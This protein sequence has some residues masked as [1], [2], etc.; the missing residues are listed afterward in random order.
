MSA[1]I[2][3][4]RR[5]TAL[6]GG[7]AAFIEDLYERYLQ[8][9][10]SIPSA[11][12]G[13][14]DAMHQEAA[15][16][17]PHGPVRENFR[18]LARER[19]SRPTSRAGGA[20]EPVAAEK[21]AAVLR[22]INAYRYRGH[23]VADLDPLVL[24]EKPQV[25]DLDP[26]YHNLQPEDF[27]QV[28][29]TGSLYAP[30]RMALREIVALV[31]QI[32]CGPVGSEYM[33]IIS[34][35]QKRWIQKR[36]EGYRAVPELDGADRRWLLTLLTAAEGLE[37]YLHNRYVGQKRFSL[38]GG[39]AL[40]PLIDELIQRAG[41]QGLKEIVIGMAHRGRL[42]V[43]TNILGK[44]PQ[45]MFDEFEGRVHVSWRE[46]AGDVKYHMGFA[47]DIDTP[48]GVVHVVL[49]FNPS[50]LEIIDP[51]IEGS[52]R[53]RQR[54]RLDRTGD[55]VLPVLIHGDAAFAGQGVVAETLQLSQ[56]RGYSTGG[57]VHIVVNNQ[58]GFT[59]S[60]PL[61]TRS[62]LYCTDVAKMVQAPV[63]HVNGDDPEAVIFATRLALDF[64]NQFHKD[65]II[66]LVCYRRL[67]HNEADEPSVTQPMM[68]KKIRGHPTVR[69]RYAERLTEAGEL[70]KDAGELMVEDYR[71]S[72]EQGVVVARPVLCGLDNPYKVDWGDCRGDDWDSAEV[73]TGVARETLC[74]LTEQMLRVP[75]GFELHPRV[76][77][78]WGER[79]NMAHGDQLINWGYAEN[80]AYATLLDAGFPVRLSGQDAG[81]GT[82]FHR[83]AVIHDQASGR[84]HTP[85]QH[86]GPHQGAFVAI[87]SILSEEA[88]LAF[89]YGYATAEP[90]A[91]TLWEAQFGDFANGAQVVIDQFITSAGTKWG[92]CC[93]LVML[94]PH[95]LEGQGA[96]HSSARIERF[97]Q[98]SA[99]RN[100]RVCVPTTPAQI[101]HLL[102]RQM[103]CKE[104]RPLIVM[105]PKSLLR[106]RLAVSGLDELAE[107]GFQP[108]IGECDPLAP[109]GVERVVVCSGRVFYD[110]L[111]ARRTRA[112]TNVAIV[113]IEQLYPFP[114]AAFTAALAQ[115][116][117]ANEV[118]W[119]QE[120][121]QNQGAWDQIK[122]RLHDL[123]PATQ[124]VYYVGR[125]TS[126]AP[127]VGH[128]A[129]HLEQQERL[130]DEA[131]TGRI[132]PSMNRRI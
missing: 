48:G 77:K 80:L 56:T 132:N 63:F 107:G 70:T 55:L 47:T 10:E 113:R 35:Q 53:A 18:R 66:D 100:I 76:E 20:L 51:V 44:P 75:E 57:T 83:H 79:R 61:D 32:Y 40:I 33:H 73:R 91:L 68:Y 88:V 25:L 67:G 127:A 97:L 50:H 84:S 86:L 37:Q 59:T 3:L 38:E 90:N 128:R 120:E 41:R 17:V 54:R 129:V 14:F 93:G 82:F 6:Y 16:E 72:I 111:E 9:P 5:S 78:I 95:G 102:R 92:L 52:V 87:D 12:R 121:A 64:R 81:R 46:M 15:N 110:L 13:H 96:E 43:L 65:V 60:N 2:E 125:P 101:F 114:R 124:R 117:A 115:F 109:E 122:H 119:C 58:I 31:R 7:N 108:V 22:L 27:D 45:D 1:R 99:E 8:D 4:F 11:W 74:A 126:A 36:L 19:R 28:F 94:L 112:L 131:L 130:V 42:N 30:N 103:L 105:T 89:E 23:Q 69:A 85:L 49:G 39:E 24:R 106:H 34:T 21:Q 62:T 104:R 118:I 26:A 29:H 116:P 123:T 71:R 98:L